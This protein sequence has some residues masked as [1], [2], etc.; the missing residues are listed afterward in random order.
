MY[1]SAK[2][3]SNADGLSRLPVEEAPKETFLP[4]EMVLTLG[5]FLDEGCPVTVSSIRAWTA[6]DP[7]LARVKGLILGGW[8]AGDIKLSGELR[9]YQQRAMELSVQDGCVMWGSRVVI[10]LPLPFK[11]GIRCKSYV[12]FNRTYLRTYVLM[13]SHTKNLM[14]FYALKHYMYIF[15]IL[16]HKHMILV[17]LSLMCSSHR[18]YYLSDVN[19]LKNFAKYLTRCLHVQVHEYC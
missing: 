19:N 12:G 8:P 9:I 13:K 15:R 16:N 3:Q 7:I 4:G 17:S 1:R 14:L 10:P 11:Y 2:E 6:K 5:A 18:C